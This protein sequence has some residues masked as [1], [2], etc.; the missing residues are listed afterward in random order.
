MLGNI[1]DIYGRALEIDP[2][3]NAVG[4]FDYSQSFA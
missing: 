2:T 3:M 1:A 4:D